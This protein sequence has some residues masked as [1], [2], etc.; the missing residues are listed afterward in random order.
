MHN[1]V[2]LFRP[3][4][5]ADWEWMCPRSGELVRPDQV[6]R[7]TVVVRVPRGFV[8]F[9]LLPDEVPVFIGNFTSWDDVRAGCE[10]WRERM[11]RVLQER[12]SAVRRDIW[13]S[14]TEA[15]L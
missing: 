4:G 14:P 13:W 10:R 1:R 7:G 11:P 12:L 2:P 8:A 15:G 6:P 5:G 9:G 3:V